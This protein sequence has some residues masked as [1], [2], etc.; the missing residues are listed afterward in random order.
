MTSRRHRRCNL[1]P[2]KLTENMNHH[3]QHRAKGATE[4]LFA[5][6]T[7]IEDHQAVKVNGLS[8]I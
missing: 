3:N 8:G 1:E 2:G 6:Q 5:I 4:L 7:G